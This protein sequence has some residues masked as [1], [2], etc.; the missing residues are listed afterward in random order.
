MNS[1]SFV[2]VRRD[3]VADLDTPVSVY[4]KLRQPH[5]F[6]LES[7][8]GGEHI[9]RYSIIG[10]DPLCRLHSDGAFTTV[11]YRDGNTVVHDAPMLPVLTACHANFRVTIPDEWTFFSGG[12]V[13]FFSWE[14]FGAIESMVFRQKPG[15]MVPDAAFIFPSSLIV[16]DHVKRLM[17]II[18]FVPEGDL[19][20]AEAR[21]DA[22]VFRITQAS[23]AVNT[24]RAVDLA[25]KDPFDVAIPGMDRETFLSM[26]IRGKEHIYEGDVFQL[27]LSQPFFVGTQKDPFDVYRSLRL[28][29]PSP[30]MFFFDMGTYQFSG[31]SP[32]ILVQLQ[33]R[34]AVVRPIAG[35]RPRIVGQEAQQQ[36]ELLL[37]EKEVAEHVMLVD[38]GRNDLGRVCSSVRTSDM[39][40]FEVYSHVIHMV[41]QVRG[42]L[43]EG[44]NAFDLFRA[45]FPA[46]T[47]SGTP[48]IRAV[49]IIDDL[50]PYRRGPYGGALGYF[51]FRGNM[52]LCIMIRTAVC[53]QKRDFAADLSLPTLPEQIYVVHVGAGIVA[54][55]V[56]D[57]EWQECRAKARGILAACL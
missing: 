2:P 27:V 17:S 18:V 53:V 8:T 30:Y 32:E 43:R 10:F 48:K 14:T 16:F 38:L 28:I 5:S 26:V 31:A 4:L 44:L 34:D 47:L 51:D 35:T 25:N 6:L 52:D 36:E 57:S 49:E 39:M 12:A 1:A 40:S 3:L 29:N 11:V 7:V 46:G 55:S 33:G 13:G 45:T 56:P 22:I 23:P 54:D 20:T 9:A 42:R 24:Y 37:D 21:L 19:H 50:E 41:S 15:V